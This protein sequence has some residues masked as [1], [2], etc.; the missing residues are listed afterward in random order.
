MGKLRNVF[1]IE[2]LPYVERCR[3]DDLE[4]DRTAGV[5]AAQAYTDSKRKKIVLRGETAIA[6]IL[7]LGAFVAAMLLG[8]WAMS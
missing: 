3:V 2:P 7:V 5:L 6:A 4:P 8:A 1:D